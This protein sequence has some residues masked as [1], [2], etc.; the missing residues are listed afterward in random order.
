MIKR[1][2]NKKD[3]DLKLLIVL[4]ILCI[5]TLVIMLLCQKKEIVAEDLVPD[6]KDEQVL[7]H[8]TQYLQS[9]MDQASEKSAVVKI[10]QGNFYFGKQADCCG[11][12]DHYCIKCR[13]NV[14]LKGEGMKTILYPVCNFGPEVQGGLDMFFYNEYRESN[15][16]NPQFLSKAVFRDFCIDGANT[17]I[18]NYNTSGKGFM[19]NLFKDCQFESLIVRNTDA[20]GIGV[21]CPINSTMKFC[22]ADNCGKAGDLS[23]GGASGIGI[24]YGYT[25]DE[26][27]LISGCQSYNNDK[28]GIF[29]EHQGK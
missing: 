11:G 29:F 20:T 12:E 1:F 18:S 23:S 14:T 9:L 19:I 27:L 7:Q 6:T 21:D 2:F 13:D 10:P 17:K 5:I 25:E 26:S 8:N 28:F 3:R 22:T 24:G 15:F 4:I 16:E